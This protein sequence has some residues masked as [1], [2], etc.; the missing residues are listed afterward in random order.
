M[1]AT[2]SNVLKLAPEPGAPAY[3]TAPHNIEAEQ[4]LLGA[5]LVN[6]D[7]FYRVSDFLE[8]KHFFEPIH[9][10]IFETAAS[11]IR[12]GK[13]AT[14]VTLKTFL[15]ADLDLGGLTVAQYLAR[16]AAEA[17]TIINA[18]DYG[19][20]IYELS[21]RR[22]LIGIGTDMVNVAYDAPVDFAPKNQIE[23]AERRLY[24]LAESGRY[25]GGFQKFSQALT[26]AVDMAA[27]AFQRDGKLSGIA[28][29]LRDLD[30]RMGGLQHSDLIVLAGRPGMGKTA[31]ATNIA[32][33]VA[34]A[35]RG[36]VQPDGSTKTVNGGIVGFFS[37]E[38]SAEQL[39]TRILAEQAEIASSKI[40]RGGISDADFDKIRDVSIELQSLPLFVDETGGLSIAQLTARAR[41]L[42]RQKGLD[43]LVVDYIQ[44]LQ[45]SSKKGDNRVQEVTEITTSLKALAKELNIPI[46]ALSQLSRQV[47]SRDD[48]RPQL[49]DLRESGSIEQD[50]D[51]V[52]FV[53][54]E[55]Y[56][57][58]NKEPRPG[59]P[60]H[61]KWATDM[62]LVHGKAE[63][64]IAKQR[65]G[66]TGT[67]DLQFEGQFTRFS[68]LTDDSHLPERI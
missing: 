55:E 63:V 16:L 21:L 19:R 54:R 43:M 26:T 56:Y 31:L 14:P 58:Q 18:Q 61:E 59:T 23:D 49:A 47:E 57:L 38:M 8:S 30:T 42:K 32:Y 34:K 1:A 45:G 33:N 27:K 7:A 17:T 13:I 9:Q 51:V 5:V 62:E 68:D 36:E 28:T 52:M 53:F 29:G 39:A 35:Y 64:I 20:T 15:A 3:R 11:I 2:D 41:R 50:A 67:V 4:A 66:P 10:T 48:K 60:E 46:I 44:L 37:C 6:N 24:E 65:H 25:E 40:R 12:A 22:D